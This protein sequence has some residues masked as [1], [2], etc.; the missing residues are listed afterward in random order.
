MR[1][2]IIGAK[3]FLGQAVIEELLTRGCEVVAIDIAWPQ[4]YL[5]Q[6]RH[7]RVTYLQ[8][9][10]LQMNELIPCL[11]GIDEIYHFAARLG[12]SELESDLRGS[13]EVNVLGALNVLEAAVKCMVPRVFLS[14]KPSVWLNTYTVTKHAAEQMARLFTRHNP[15]QVSIM[16]FLN[17]YGP[18]QKLAPVRKILPV[19]AAQ[20]LRGLP[21]QIYGNGEQTV[22]MIFSRDTARITVDIMRAPFSPD[23]FDCGTGQEITVNAVAEAVNHYFAN[24]AGIVHIDMRRGETPNTRLVADIKPLKKL[25]PEVSFTPWDKGLAESLKWYEDLPAHHIDAA[26][27]FYGIHHRYGTSWN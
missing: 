1:A 20:A 12:T 15:V 22:D 21:I 6:H 9:D 24:R 13:M 14:S 11:E 8:A 2:A 18:G 27:S 26:L 25:L 19:F 10:I 3:G 5:N 17:V 16:R 23:P 4:N 7:E